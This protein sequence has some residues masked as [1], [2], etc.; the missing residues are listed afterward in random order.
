MTRIIES[1]VKNIH[2]SA[3]ADEMVFFTPEPIM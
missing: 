1:G 3:S 2:D